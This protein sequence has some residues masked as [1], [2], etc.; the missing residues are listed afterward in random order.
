VEKQGVFTA[1]FHPHGWSDPQ[2]WVDLIDYAEKTY[3]KRVK[4]LNFR[5]AL[6]RLEKNAL[7]GKS[8]RAASGADNGIRLMDV[9]GDGFM[10]VV[11]GGPGKHTT[12]VWQP[13]E[14]RWYETATPCPLA[15]D[16][17][18]G[19]RHTAGVAFGILRL[20]GGATMLSLESEPHAWTFED[21]AWKAD[22]ALVHGLPG[23]TKVLLR[24]FDH[25][26]VCE[27]LANR[28]ILSWNEKDQH[29]QAADFTLPPECATL[30][31][32]GGDNGLRF[33]DLNGDGF[34]DV[35]QSNDQG[36]AIDLWAGTVKAR[37]G[38]SHGWPHL[39][40][41]GSAAKDPRQAKVL[42]FVK[43][44][45]DYGAWVYRDRIVWQNEDIAA[46]G[47]ESVQ[48]TF[49]ELI[50]FDVPPPKSPE[51]SL[52]TLR[53]PPGFTADLVAAEPMIESP[54]RFDW[55]AKGRLWVLEMPDYPLGVDGQG[56]PGGIVKILTD[57][58]GDGHYD[59]VTTFMDHVPFPTALMPW[60]NGV[61]VGSASNILFVPDTDGQGHAGEPRVLF[62]GFK[63]GNQQHREN[64][65][66]WGLDGWLYGANGDSGGT[67]SSVAHKGP[68]AAKDVS[69]SN[70]DFRFKPDTG[71]FEAESGETQYG[72]H[73]D[74]WGN[75]FGNYNSAWLWHYTIDEHYLRRNPRLAVKTTKQAL[76]NYSDPTRVFPIS[77]LPIRFNDPGALGHVTSGCSA[78]PYRD[79]LFGAEYSRSVFA[80][81]PVHNAV[82]RE[83]LEPDGATFTSHRANEELDREFL[84]ST[85]GWFRPVYLKTGPDGALYVADFYRF[86]L[87][88]PEWIA[89]ETMNRLD[90]RQGADRGRIY[91]IKPKGAKLR[92]VPNLEKLDN[93]ELAAS[94][95]SANAWQRDTAQR[96]LNERQ[97]TEETPL[98]R[99]LAAMASN[100]KVRVQA[101]A[102]LDTLRTLDPS[103]IASALHDPHPGVRVEALRA[104][105]SLADQPRNILPALLGCLEDKDFVVRR[106]LALSLGAFHD[107]SATAALAKLAEREGD[108]PQMRLAILS[109]LQPENPLFAKLNAVNVTAV[110]KIELP[111]PTTPDRAKVVAS[112]ASVAGLK[113]DRARGHQLFTQTCTIC[114]R[115][116]GEGQDVGPDLGQVGEKPVDWLLVAIFDPSAQVEPRY[117]LHTLKLKSGTELAGI[118]AAETGNNIVL[119]LPGGTDLPVLRADIS[120]DEATTRSLMP[121]GLETVLKPQDV[122][123][124]ISWLRAK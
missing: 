73:R 55:D 118:V 91:R 25:D 42:P 111:K 72:R 43:D 52:A 99:Y 46:P 39:V 12:R 65:Y 56:K 117:Y 113:G 24:D 93:A 45:R 37:L 16:T 17:A 11:M 97:A 26:G 89:P 124:I 40:A 9:D 57:T 10:D 38:W 18:E 36:Y 98:L 66:E 41:R 108:Q 83:V 32:R 88:H 85:D 7:A 71:E 114:H 94:L 6:E 116:R 79:D 84:A 80:C 59:K 31:A 29:W 122:A 19:W 75:W 87:E 103:V 15:I 1:V 82:H 69:I 54:V 14:K 86:V 81:E 109:S 74:D 28:D 63:E 20:S 44:G 120:K 4:F 58:R 123:D 107:E 105:E 13:K 50:A 77:E 96:L 27:M 95:N 110:P 21:R 48:H 67:V 60:R 115:L 3:G 34:E 51:D 121:E 35:I 106:Q 23:G 101:V 112:Y 53:L 90:V 49:K 119:R 100:P 104:S 64:G 92:P 78:T 102:T 8:L 33:V 70:R 47:A 76:A 22:D 62:T 5:E 68:G 2:Q 30:N 61:L